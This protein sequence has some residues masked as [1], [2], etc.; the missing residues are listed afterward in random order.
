MQPARRTPLSR[1][2]PPR[3]Q[4]FEH[5]ALIFQTDGPFVNAGIFYV[6]HARDGDAAAW[7]LQEL[8]RRIARFTYEPE[9]VRALPHSGWARA[10]YFSNAD[11]QANMNDVVASSLSGQLSFAGGVEFMEARFK[12]RFAPRKCFG[13]PARGGASG[14]PARAATAWTARASAC[15]TAD[16]SLI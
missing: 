5:H 1:R 15:A 2:R 11:E 7:V 4:E 6:Q 8:N 3:R 10:P 14:R 12:E 16:G 13:R 9:S